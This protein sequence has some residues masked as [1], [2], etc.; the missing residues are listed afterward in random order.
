MSPANKHPP[1]ATYARQVIEF[2]AYRI[3]S[4]NC[5]RNHTA[6]YSLRGTAFRSG[7]GAQL[8]LLLVSAN[9]PGSG[10]KVNSVR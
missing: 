1:K 4:T 3:H 6:F 8:F 2:S 5:R 9:C 10:Q 7:R